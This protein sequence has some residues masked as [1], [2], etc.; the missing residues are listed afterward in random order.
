VAPELDGTRTLDE[1]VGGL[2]ADKRGAVERLVGELAEQ[3]AH[4]AGSDSG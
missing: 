2:P 4:E 3:R 1:L